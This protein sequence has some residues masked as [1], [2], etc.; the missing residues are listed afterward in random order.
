MRDVGAIVL[1]AGASKR[2]GQ[3]K[4][5]LTIDGE[6]LVRRIVNAASAAGCARI[7]VVV[8]ATRDRIAAE[9]RGT[10]AEIVDNDEWQRG[11]GTSIRRGVEYLVSAQP[12]LEAVML[13]VCDQPFVD[14][15]IIH[16]LIDERDRSGKPIVASSYDAASPNIVMSTEVETSLKEISGRDS[17]TSVGMTKEGGVPALFDRVCFEALLRLPDDSG[18]KPLIEADL[19]RVAWIAFPEGAIDIDTPADLA[20]LPTLR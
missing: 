11:L 4:Q 7:A 19:T 5:L 3:P 12:D 20:R 10:A 17:S 14:R 15:A 16:A 18:A 6:A 8:G 9:L 2:L 13:L 1:A